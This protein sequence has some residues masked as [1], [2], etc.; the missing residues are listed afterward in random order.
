[1]IYRRTE[2]GAGNGTTRV[3]LEDP[4]YILPRRT[5][6]RPT[7]VI[8]SRNFRTP[9]RHFRR[10]QNIPTYAPGKY[11]IPIKSPKRTNY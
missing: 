5:I 8:P 3:V 4:H 11:L 9:S 7:I 10:Q 2:F 6:I 1:M